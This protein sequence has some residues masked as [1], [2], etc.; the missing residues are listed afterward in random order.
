MFNDF[1]QSALL[2]LISLEILIINLRIDSLRKSK[3]EFRHWR[4]G[5]SL[6]G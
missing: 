6:G 4:V 3:L 2:H 1:V 5:L